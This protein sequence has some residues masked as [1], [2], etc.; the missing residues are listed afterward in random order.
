MLD[1]N[2]TNIM[3]KMIS[4]QNLCKYLYYTS[5]NPLIEPD[6]KDAGML[7]LNN[8]FPIPKIPTVEE[9]ASSIINVVLDNFTLHKT[10]YKNSMIIFNIMVHIDLWLINELINDEV[11]NKIRPFKILNEMDI[12]FNGQRV[13]GIGKLEI[14]NCKWLI[15][16]DKYYGYLLSY[17][18][19]EFN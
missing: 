13:V 9:N 18:V 19:T 7:L 15:Y 2:M 12:L 17:N 14:N 5:K 16:N 3:L 8:I 10:A 1:E 6:I 4:S 11:K